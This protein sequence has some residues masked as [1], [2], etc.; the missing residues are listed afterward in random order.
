[1]AVNYDPRRYEVLAAPGASLSQH[2]S[3]PVRRRR[4]TN[5]DRGFPASGLPAADRGFPA[6]G[7]PAALPGRSSEEDT[8]VYWQTVQAMASGSWRRD[9]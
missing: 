6:S 1:V 4:V 5:V 7:L 9:R 8:P 3:R 2:E